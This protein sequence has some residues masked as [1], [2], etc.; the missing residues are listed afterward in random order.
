MATTCLW[1]KWNSRFYAFAFSNFSLTMAKGSAKKIHEKN[2][3]T[4]S[5]LLKTHAG[6]TAFY[7]LWRVFFLWSS[8]SKWHIIGWALANGLFVWLYRSLGASATPSFGPNGVIEDAG[9]D[10]SAEGLVAYMFDIIYI[11]WFVLVATAVISDKFW[12]TYLV[13][14]GFAAYKIYDKV[15][16]CTGSDGEH[17]LIG[18]SSA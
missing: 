6:V 9:A 11:G 2:T 14:P 1:I 4:L 7:I 12:W 15:G 10:L 17:Y 8:L 16:L 5:N 3:Q 18:F 13:V